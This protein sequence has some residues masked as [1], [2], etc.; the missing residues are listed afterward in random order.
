MQIL[1]PFKHFILD[2]QIWVSAGTNPLW[3]PRDDLLLS[4]KQEYEFNILI[5]FFTQ[6]HGQNYSVDICSFHSHAEYLQT[7]LVYVLLI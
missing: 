6:D 1:C 7:I 5:F 2:L 3:I 4:F